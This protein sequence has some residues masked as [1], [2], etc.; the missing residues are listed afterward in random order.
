MVLQISQPKLQS[1]TRGSNISLGMHKPGY[2]EVYIMHP[3]EVYC[4]VSAPPGSSE[5]KAIAR[6]SG[7]WV[8]HHIP[9]VVFQD[10]H[11]VSAMQAGGYEPDLTPRQ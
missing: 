7:G 4:M 9:G 11:A 3:T 5:G 10:S 8:T 1:Q 2:I 6:L